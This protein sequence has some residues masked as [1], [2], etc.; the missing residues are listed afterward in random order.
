MVWEVRGKQGGCLLW[1][2]CPCVWK[3][4][5]AVSLVMRRDPESD[6]RLAPSFSSSSCKTLDQL[7]SMSQHQF[8]LSVKW[9]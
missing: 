8:L 6:C 7:L 5:P 2:V 1:P 4:V 3:E 9:G